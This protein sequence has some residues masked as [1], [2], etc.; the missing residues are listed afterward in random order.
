MPARISHWRK[1][2]LGR[3]TVEVAQHKKMISCFEGHCMSLKSHKSQ[4]RTLA[5]KLWPTM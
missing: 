3:D 5:Q 2:Q 1:N 4:D